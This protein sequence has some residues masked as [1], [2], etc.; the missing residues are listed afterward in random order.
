MQ[1]ASIEYIQRIDFVS[2]LKYLYKND[3][4][5][6]V[7]EEDDIGFHLIVYNDPCSEKSDEDYLIDSLEE[8]FQEAEQKFGVTSG[9]WKLKTI[10]LRPSLNDDLLWIITWYHD[11][12]DGDWENENGI[13]I[14][15]LDNP[16]WYLSV[17]IRGTLCEAKEFKDI[18]VERSENDWFHCFVRDGKFEGPCG[19]FNLME[20]LQIFRN[21]VEYC[22]K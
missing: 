13:R 10:N 6:L 3:F 14:G 5:K 11:Q 18:I 21:W 8:A 1:Q 15:T 9:Q 22:Q 20:V 19:P 12:C 16:G 17:S 2:Y 4:F 7:I